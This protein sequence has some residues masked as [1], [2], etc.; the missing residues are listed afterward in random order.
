MTK[1]SKRSFE[2]YLEI[3]HRES[4]GIPCKQ[5]AAVHS[6]LPA[7]GGKRFQLATKRC[8]HCPRI[9]VLRPERV[10]AR[11][12]CPKCDGFVCDDCETTRV[13]TGICRTWKQQVDEYMDAAAKGRIILP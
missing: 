9:V 10:R 13:L 4:P 8:S 3:D 2:G 11:G 1:V 5:S 6:L 7:E 12:Y